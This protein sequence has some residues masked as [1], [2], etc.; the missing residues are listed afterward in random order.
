[1][2]KITNDNYAHY[3]KIAEVVWR[4]QF[5]NYPP[6]S[7]DENALPVNVLNRWEQKNR[8]LAKSGLKEGLLD[9]L[10]MLLDAPEP[11]LV[12]LNNELLQANLPGLGQLMSLVTDVPA[13][14]LKRGSIS[15]IQEWY[16]IKEMLGNVEAFLTPTDKLKLELLFFDFENSRRQKSAE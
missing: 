3:K 2:F 14:V 13:K 5:K 10:T 12:E 1:M 7:I 9:S 8:P 15:S 6:G 4:F 11:Y 16:V